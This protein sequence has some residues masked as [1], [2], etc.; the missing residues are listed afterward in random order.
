MAKKRGDRYRLLVYERMWQSW[1]LP[2][3]MI[4]PASLA[5]WWFAPRATFLSPRL[6]TLTLVPAIISILILM[7][8][9]AA[10]RLAWVQCR[11]GYLRIQTPIVPLAISYGRIQLARLSTL[12]EVVRIAGRK[13]RKWQWLRPH[14]GRT[15]LVLEL[16]KYPVSKAWLRLWFSPFL[17][18][19]NI[20]GFVF[21]VKDWMALSR[22]LD[23]FRTQYEARQAARRREMAERQYYGELY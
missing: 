5:L 1:A 20:T 19:P 23:D 13:A 2:C 11:P 15:V 3:L 7:Y 22:Q 18:T 10:R 12:A 21:I 14:W 8:A 9:H 16:G 6:R 17:L 4:A